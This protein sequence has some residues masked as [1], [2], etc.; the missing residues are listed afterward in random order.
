MSSTT[1]FSNW[2][3]NEG[4]AK[5]FFG[6]YILGQLGYF[7]FSYY[8]LWTAS[9]I[10]LFRGVLGHGLPIARGAANVI[11]L[12]CAIILFTVCRNTISG[13][14][15]TFLGRIIPFDKNITFHIWIAYSIAFWTLVHVVAHYV[16]YLNVS[17][18]LPVTPMSH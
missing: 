1:S 10:T 5:I 17:K 12:N 7:G 18:A 14:R 11:N 6:L 4:R 9:D 2:M 15:S 3:I 16:N 13:L 8:S